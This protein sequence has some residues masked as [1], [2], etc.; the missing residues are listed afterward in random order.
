MFL[1]KTSVLAAMAMASSVSGKLFSCSSASDPLCLDSLVNN[2]SNV[3]ST[4]LGEHDTFIFQNDVVGNGSA[5]AAMTV[6]F[7]RGTAEP[8]MSA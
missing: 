3:L 7:A 4:I 8:G 2:T 6:L 1:L 5:C